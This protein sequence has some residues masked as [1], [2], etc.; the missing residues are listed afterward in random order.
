[1]KK[2]ISLLLVLLLGLS[3]MQTAAA[4]DD[5]TKQ[6]NLVYYLWGS[7]G[8]ANPDILAKINEKL[9]A[10]LN[11]TIEIRYIDWGEIATK[12]PLL[13][14]SGEKFDMSHAS[15]TAAVSYYTL[16][17]QGVLADITD[18]LDSVPA[19]RDAIPENTWAGAK[20]QGRIYGVPTLYSEFTPYGYAYR[21]DLREK[22]GLEP[23]TSLETMEA[24]LAAVVK[25][26]T[27][28][29]INGNADDAINLYRMF[30][31]LTGAWI[32]APGL[33][34][35]QV[36]LV[37]T[38]PENYQDLIHPA[39]TE[40]FMA[41]AKK[42]KEWADAGYFAKDVLAAQVGAKDNTNNG[43]SAGF[44]THMPDWTGNYGT[45]VES[46]P[47]VTINWWSPA[48][49]NGKVLI[50][51]GVDNSTAISITSANPER[52]LKV[53]EKF[54]TDESYYRLIQY[55]IEGRQYEL[56]DGLSVRPAGYDVQKDGGGFAVWSLRNDA[57]NI[58]YATENPVRYELIEAWKKTAIPNPYSGFTFDP[59]N[60]SSELAAISDV[61]IELGRQI[62]LGKSTDDVEAAVENYRSMLKAAGIDAVLAEVKAQLAN[63]TPI[64]K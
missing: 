55:G 5:M 54:M 63:F 21:D 6:V 13:F 47:G 56:K 39:F 61:N 17:A 34:Q 58:P 19:L 48:V 43:I 42:M 32:T 22:Y 1:M 28:A 20:Y 50:K 53:I 52:A 51:A 12:Y 24:Y 25:N 59:T 7:A 9:T 11:C 29:P 57:F 41:W 26:E 23:I 49:D 45:Q 35:N 27:F 2:L 16:A 30:T 62:L 37:A 46:L 31:D 4:A 18:L 40:E 64:G 33:P 10:D 8:V 15:P 60:V 38:S 36:Y 44:L 14:A 3:M